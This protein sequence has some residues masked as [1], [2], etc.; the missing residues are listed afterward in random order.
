MKT[1]LILAAWAVL[2]GAFVAFAG[3][4]LPRTR[5]LDGT[6]WLASPHAPADPQHD[7]AGEGGERGGAVSF[8]KESFK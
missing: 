1:A 7:Q 8:H 6:G 3:S 2:P 5:R 4:R